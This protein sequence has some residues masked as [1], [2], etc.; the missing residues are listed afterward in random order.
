M[1][2]GRRMGNSTF[3]ALTSTSHSY[4]SVSLSLNCEAGTKINS[5]LRSEINYILR[6]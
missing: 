2:E 6:Q 5:Q 4:T 3:V 1:D